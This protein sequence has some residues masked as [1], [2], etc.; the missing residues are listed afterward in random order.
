MIMK[1]DERIVDEMDGGREVARNVDY[2]ESGWPSVREFKRTRG[3]Y[4]RSKLTRD[5]ARMLPDGIEVREADAYLGLR[6]ITRFTLVES[7]PA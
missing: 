3:R 2:F 1:A 4:Y 6:S 7:V 5:T